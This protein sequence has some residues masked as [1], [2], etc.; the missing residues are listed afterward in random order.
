M[1]L[2]TKSKHV[3]SGVCV[4]GHDAD[5]HHGN[6]IMNIEAGKLMESSV[7]YAECERFGCNEWWEPCPDCPK[8]F[9]D[10]DDPLKLTKLAE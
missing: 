8:G 9:I 7:F 6:M 1:G 2:R 10:K 5:E 4:C 3:F